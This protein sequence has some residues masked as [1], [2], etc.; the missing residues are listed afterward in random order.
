[1]RY[2]EPGGSVAVAFATAKAGILMPI[3][4]IANPRWGP[5]WLTWL[6]LLPEN[7]YFSLASG[8]HL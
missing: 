6:Y 4:A 3:P 2:S 1:M 5:R 8:I 7:C